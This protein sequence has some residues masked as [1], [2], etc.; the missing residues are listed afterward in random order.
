MPGG[1]VMS[2]AAIDT[3]MEKEDELSVL[4]VALLVLFLAPLSIDVAGDKVSANYLFGLLLLFPFRAYRADLLGFLAVCIA[5]V[6]WVV[7]VFLFSYGDGDFLTR[8][9]TSALIW[10]APVLLL[11]L[12]LPFTLRELCTATVIA[13]V[14]YSVYVA[15]G[16]SHEGLS[17][18]D[19]Y[20]IKAK[21]RESVSDWPQR[22]VLL[23]MF[24]FY[25]ALDRARNGLVW[26]LAAV[27]IGACIFV[28][29]TRAAWLA[30]F[31]ALPG[32]WY[33]GRRLGV[34]AKRRS[35]KERVF[36]VITLLLIVGAIGWASTSEAVVKGFDTIFENMSF[37][38]GVLFSDG[39]SLQ[40][41]GSEETRLDV[42]KGVL[43]VVAKSPL[44][45]TGFAGAGLLVEGTGSAHSQYFDALLRTG[46][47]GLVLYFGFWAKALL[48]YFRVN[49]GIFA[50]LVAIFI[51]G[52]MHESTKLSYAAFIFF[53]LLNKA[54]EI[55]ERQRL[56][57]PVSA[58]LSPAAQLAQIGR[59]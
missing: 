40:A 32:Y 23:L 31:L 16:I 33:V 42:W 57:A 29:F 44:T 19:A 27:I 46:V 20:T 7:G 49:A 6:S 43:E 45:G 37:V 25:V 26:S 8:Q 1:M 59:T 54:A 21:L 14:G 13:G 56:A 55:T 4:K 28:T 2:A 22:Y 24:A 38:A 58:N 52:F 39:N 18:A 50:G 17:I 47:I 36:K 48:F 11:F 5:V 30:V 35:G 9:A 3:T 10:L 12:R 34:E 53:F 41:A 15:W 51:F